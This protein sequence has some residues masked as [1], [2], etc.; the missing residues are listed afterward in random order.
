MRSTAMAMA[1][2]PELQKRLM[3]IAGTRSGKPARRAAPRAMLFPDSAS[4]IAQPSI[5]SSTSSGLTWGYRCSSARITSAARS[6]GR[7]L[8]SVPR[9]AF[10]TA[11]RRQSIITASCIL[12]SIAQ[13]LTCLQHVLNPLLCLGLAAEAEESLALQVQQILFGDGLFAG[14]PAAAQYICQFFAD[15]GV[16]V[17][18]VPAFMREVNAGFEQSEFGLAADAY[19]RARQAG[20]VVGDQRQSQGFRISDQPLRVHGD[21]VL[22]PKKAERARVLRGGRDL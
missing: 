9:G 13:R 15:L 6:S 19:V 10:P 1:W 5:T 21:L 8:R 3:V 20:R 7:V 12:T 2:R 22:R 16:I 18:Y 17:G 4:G 14:D 11:A